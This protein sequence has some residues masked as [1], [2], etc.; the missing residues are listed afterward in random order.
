MIYS[1]INVTFTIIIGI[2]LF[3]VAAVDARTKEIPNILNLALLLCGIGAIWIWTDV[4]IASRIIGIF[5]VSFP[6]LLLSVLITGAFGGGDI[7]L[8]ASTGFL[9]GWQNILI[10]A[11]IGI[12]LGGIYGGVL[13]VLGIKERRDHFA[14]GPFLAFSIFYVLVWGKDTLTIYFQII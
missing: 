13:L 10:A 12:I 2:L 6:M 1:P 7:K 3:I 8:M 4:T 9:L 14:F 11:F 5:V